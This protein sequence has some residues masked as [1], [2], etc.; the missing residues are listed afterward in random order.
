[1]IRACFVFYEL[2]KLRQG[3]AHLDA[4]YLSLVG[5][6]FVSD[7]LEAFYCVQGFGAFRQKFAVFVFWSPLF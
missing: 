7:N 1:M 2:T 4:L 5:R 6:I 3:L